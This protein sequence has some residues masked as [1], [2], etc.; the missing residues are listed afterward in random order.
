MENQEIERKFLVKTIPPDLES[1]PHQVIQQA[2]VAI[3]DDGTEV[4]LRKK[5]G[6][7]FQT[8]KNG[9]GLKRQEIE[10]ELTQAQFEKLWLATG[11]RQIN[12]VRYAI[13]HGELTIELDIYGGLLSGFATAEVE[14]SSEAQSREFVPPGWFGEDVTLD[15][16]YKNKNLAIQGMPG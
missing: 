6:K 3:T 1:Y 2:Y 11:G 9:E 8:V 7:Y 15:K 10:I 14:F 5:G 13:K 4:R 12:K 16:R